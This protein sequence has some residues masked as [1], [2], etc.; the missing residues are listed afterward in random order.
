VKKS[1]GTKGSIAEYRVACH[2]MQLN[3][4]VFK[5]LSV[6]GPVDLLALKGRRQ[7]LRVQVKS[8]LSMNQFKNM[9]NG[10][11]ELLAVLVDGEIR[12]RALNRRV[13]AMVPGSVL[14][15]RPKRPAQPPKS[16]TKATK[17]S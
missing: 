8:T 16:H 2:L 9:R 12:Y 15:R 1:P 13:Q 4:F 17:T 7:I 14:A 5:N 3:F 10:N 11:C 6:N